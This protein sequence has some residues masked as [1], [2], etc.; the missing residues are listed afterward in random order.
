MPN[1]AK[2]VRGVVLDLDE[3]LL[4]LENRSRWQWAWR[5]NGPPI[6]ERHVAAA[7]RR[8]TRAW[9]RRRW[10]GLVGAEPAA[11]F[12]DYR[13]QV[14]RTLVAVAD[15][16]LPDEEVRAV[17]DRF[18][19]PH[20]PFEVPPDVPDGLAVLAARGIPIAVLSSLPPEASKALL[21]RVGVDPSRL[22]PPPASGAPPPDRAAFR[23][24]AQ[25]LGLA[26]SETLYLGDLYWSDVRAAARAGLIAVQIDRAERSAERG[27][28][29]LRSLREL[30][31]LLDRPPGT[32][33]SD[34]PPGPPEEAGPREPVRP[35]ASTAGGDL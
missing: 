22:V 11:T 13:V 14:A 19:G 16:P 9:D 30:G 15:R 5:P 33:G 18:L 20:G 26:P 21:P 17:V 34:G 28:V 25:L 3:T 8:E 27:G 23:A 7:L 4:P 12:D 35:G 29:R 1:P 10:R 2:P 31:G 24:A 6:P 32:E